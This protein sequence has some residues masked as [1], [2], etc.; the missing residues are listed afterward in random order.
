MH[1]SS[2]G[3]VARTNLGVACIVV[4]T[5]CCVRTRQHA[6]L[7][8]REQQGHAKW[9]TMLCAMKKLAEADAGGPHGAQQMSSVGCNTC[10]KRSEHH[11]KTQTQG[12]HTHLQHGG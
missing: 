5:T 6:N 1:Q 12:R 9:P 7:T 8:T 2:E 3:A 4:A 10:H 11:L